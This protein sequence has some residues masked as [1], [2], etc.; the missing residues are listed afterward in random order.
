MQNI[1]V[2]DDIVRQTEDLVS[3]FYDDEETAYVFTADHGMSIIGNHGDGRECLSES[4][5]PNCM[6]SDSHIF[7]APRS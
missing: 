3:S 7:H 2:V 5:L 4:L 6:P 1:M